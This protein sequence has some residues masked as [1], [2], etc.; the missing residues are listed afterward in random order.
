MSTTKRRRTPGPSTTHALAVVLPFPPP[1]ARWGHYCDP[2]APCPRCAEL[3]FPEGCAPD[4][5]AVGR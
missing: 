3:I 4:R 1:R 5:R 2:I